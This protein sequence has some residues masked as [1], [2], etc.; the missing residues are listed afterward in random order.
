MENIQFEP[1]KLN[2]LDPVPSDIDISQ[3]VT[4]KNIMKVAKESG[5]REDEI[6]LYGNTKAKIHLSILE[7]LKNQPNGK[8]VVV[9]GIN[10]TPL[11]EGKSTTTVGLAQALGAHL[12][13]RTFACLRQPS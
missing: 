7:R 8:Y 5:I 6:D 3:S 1:I 10:P 12:N 4:P 2:L 11:G 13:K 9:T